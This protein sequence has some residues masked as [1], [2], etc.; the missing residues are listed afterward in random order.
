MQVVE[1]S[2]I[3]VLTNIE[4]FLGANAHP[5]GTAI[6]LKSIKTG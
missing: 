1:Y 5:S 6:I 4:I 3:L 2:A